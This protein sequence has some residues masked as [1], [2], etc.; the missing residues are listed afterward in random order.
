MSSSKVNCL[1]TKSKVS[2]TN[3]VIQLTGPLSATLR[4]NGIS[5]CIV[6]DNQ[7]APY[8]YPLKFS[9]DKH[10]ISEEENDFAEELF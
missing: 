2:P 6:M 3:R 10:F 5:G 7:N 8:K 9:T 1:P 4:N